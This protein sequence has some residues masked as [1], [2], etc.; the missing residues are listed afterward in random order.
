[1][2]FIFAV[3]SSA[4]TQN[5]P[6]GTAFVATYEKFMLNQTSDVVFPYIPDQQ[7][8]LPLPFKHADDRFVNLGLN[9]RPTF[10]GCNASNFTD[11]RRTPPLTIYFPHVPWTAFTNFTT[12][13]LEYSQANV[14]AYIENG[15]A[16]AV[17]LS[18]TGTNVVARE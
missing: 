18:Q 16:T 2:D 12:F 5:W 10:F 15:V 8:S 3:D 6:N 7:T 1:V 11:F 17:L 4:D 13:T 14:T 9:A